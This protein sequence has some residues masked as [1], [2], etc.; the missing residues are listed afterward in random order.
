M[1]ARAI[2]RGVVA[3][4]LPLLPVPLLA[5]GLNIDHK[6]IGCIVAEKYPKMNACFSPASGL[7][8]A[9]VYFRAEQGPPNWYYVEMKSE[10]PCH[11]GI[12]PKPNKEL[13]GKRVLY[14]V[15]AFDQKF[16][17]NRTVDNAALVV[18][19]ESEC[20]KDV[21]VAPFVTSASVAVFPAVPAGF[22]TGGIG[23]AAVAAVVG[24]AAV[25]GAVVALGTTTRRRRRN[26]RVRVRRRCR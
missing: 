21:P 6:P 2:G 12:L 17:E 22:A 16:A 3:F 25:V 4:L 11:A 13:I 9:R 26:P 5:Q 24:G 8:R 19:S 18:K 10:A 1:L 15:N 20:K 7:A 23:T 14:Y